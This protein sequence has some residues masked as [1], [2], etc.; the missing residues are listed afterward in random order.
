MNTTKTILD[1]GI[2][3]KIINSLF[4]ENPQ[5]LVSHHIESF[6]DFYKKVFNKFSTRT[7]H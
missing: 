5:C 1:N 6:N 3:W 7:I 4:E 2:L